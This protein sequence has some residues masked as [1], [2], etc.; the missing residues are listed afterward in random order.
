MALLTVLLCFA[1]SAVTLNNG[2][3][4]SAWY[5]IT[6]LDNR[7]AETIG[8]LARGEDT[9]GVETSRYGPFAFSMLWARAW[10]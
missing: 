2:F 10:T 3:P 7:T 8:D 1:R 9:E 4:S 6:T 5:D